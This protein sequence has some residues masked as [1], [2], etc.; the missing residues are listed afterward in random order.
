M[1]VVV[2]VYYQGHILGKQEDYSHGSLSLDVESLPPHKGATI[3]SLNTSYC[4]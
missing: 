2:V 1:D 4:P 3:K